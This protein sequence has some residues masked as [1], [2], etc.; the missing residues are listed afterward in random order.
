[1]FVSYATHDLHAFPRELDCPC[2]QICLRVVS[3]NSYLHAVHYYASKI[4]MAAVL[5]AILSAATSNR[6]VYNHVSLSN[7]HG[8]E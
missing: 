2:T 7:V 1:M 6:H 4:T 3:R 5:S 8:L